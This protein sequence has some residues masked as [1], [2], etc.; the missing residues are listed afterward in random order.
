MALI[1]ELAFLLTIQSTWGA[2][3]LVENASN[4]IQKQKSIKVY[5]EK[6]PASAENGL[7]NAHFPKHNFII[8]LRAETLELFI[9]AT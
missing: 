1:N 7:G 3:D 2:L 8:C 9:F 5:Q 6:V 4:E